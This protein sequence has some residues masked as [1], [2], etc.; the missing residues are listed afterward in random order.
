MSGGALY[1]RVIVYAE[2][3]PRAPVGEGHLVQLGFE[4]CLPQR[5]GDV[6]D[7]HDSDFDKRWGRFGRV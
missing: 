3:S 4:L 6:A 1:E 2:R 7:V 5:D